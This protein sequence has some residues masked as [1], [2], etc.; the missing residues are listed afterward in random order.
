MSRTDRARARGL[1]R[2]AAGDAADVPVQSG[3]A[4]WTA[5]YRIHGQAGTAPSAAIVLS[6][7]ASSL[8]HPMTAH[9]PSTR[10]LRGWPRFRK[11][12]GSFHGWAGALAVSSQRARAARSQERRGTLSEAEGPARYLLVP[13]IAVCSSTPVYAPL[14][15]AD[16]LSS[17]DVLQNHA[18]QLY[19]EAAPFR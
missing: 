3:G 9:G 8:L 2:A 1:R 4:R 7:S 6:L 13:S 14:V 17:S 10:R 19:G 5:A 16:A 11:R 12:V 15:P 18:M